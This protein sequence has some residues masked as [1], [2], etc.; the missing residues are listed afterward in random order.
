MYQFVRLGWIITVS[1]LLT[2]SLSACSLDLFDREPQSEATP[3][4]SRQKVWQS[5]QQYVEIVSAE[6][7]SNQHPVIITEQV[8]KTVL[9]SLYVKERFI[10]RSY[11]NPVYSVREQQILSTALA[12]ALKQARRDEDVTFMMLAMHPDAFGNKQKV[13]SGRIFIDDAGRLNI[14]FAALHEDYSGTDSISDL[15]I[16]TRRQGTDLNAV[17]DLGIGQTF[18]VDPNTGEQRQDWV[19]IDIP[20]VLANKQDS[21]ITNTRYVSPELLQDVAQGKQEAG[22]LRQEVSSMKEVLFELTDEVQRLRK[23]V[24]ELKADR[25]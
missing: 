9:S 15:S 14:I 19:M 13:N 6:A 17:I 25:P 2:A 12:N 8:L 22:N 11:R 23:E 5:G 18:Y 10:L 7:T 20:A 1:I 16:A 4:E 24:K 21:S 3:I